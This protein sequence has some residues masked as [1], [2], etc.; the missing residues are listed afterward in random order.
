MNDDKKNEHPQLD[1]IA[2]MASAGMV[3]TVDPEDADLMAAFEDDALTAEDALASRF[4][5]EGGE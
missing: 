4:D 2:E 5:E 1:Q 3:V